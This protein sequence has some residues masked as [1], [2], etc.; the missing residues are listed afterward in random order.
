LKERRLVLK[1]DKNGF[2]RKKGKGKT[3]LRELL[4]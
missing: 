3:V 2:Q 1:E 4:A